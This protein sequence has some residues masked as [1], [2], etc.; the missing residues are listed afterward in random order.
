MMSDAKLQQFKFATLVI[1]YLF[2]TATLD[3][4][5]RSLYYGCHANGTVN[6]RGSMPGSRLRDAGAAKF[7]GSRTIF[8]GTGGRCLIRTPRKSSFRERTKPV[9]HAHV[10]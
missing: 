5:L 1:Q 3:F 7:E 10:R 2:V 9:L 4:P 8:A 6:D